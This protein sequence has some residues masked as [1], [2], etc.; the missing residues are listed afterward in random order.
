M[1]SDL[2]DYE[3]SARSTPDTVRSDVLVEQL[4]QL[5]E[6]RSQLVEQLRD[7]QNER[8]AVETYFKRSQKD[9]ALQGLYSLCCFFIYT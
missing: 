4:Q 9:L 3:R 1:R 5:Q 6:E 2:S 8:Q 7:E